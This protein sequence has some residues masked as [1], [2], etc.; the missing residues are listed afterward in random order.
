MEPRSRCPMLYRHI[1]LSVIISLST[2]GLIH[3]PLQSKVQAQIRV[4]SQPL[5]G[6]IARSPSTGARVRM[7]VV[8]ES[9]TGTLVGS[10]GPAS[11][12]FG[13]GSASG[14]EA[15]QSAGAARFMVLPPDFHTRFELD[16]R[17][18]DVRVR[19]RID[20]EAMPC[21]SL[22][23]TS[24]SRDGRASAAA[25]PGAGG[26]ECVLEY[27]LVERPSMTTRRL[28]IVVEDVN[29]WAPSFQ[30]YMAQQ[31][32]GYQSYIRELPENSEPF[33][34]CVELPPPVD[35]DAGR[36]GVRNVSVRGGADA[37][38]FRVRLKQVPPTKFGDLC[39]YPVVALDRE[40]QESYRLQIEAL[41]G[42]SPPRSGVLNLSL[43]IAD[44]NDNSP[45]FERERFSVTL[46]ENAARDSLVVRVMAH[47]ADK[48]DNAALTYSF[49]LDEYSS[50]PNMGFGDIVRPPF[51]IDPQS[52][53]LISDDTLSEDAQK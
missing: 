23:S 30:Q 25:A 42:G 47:D 32:G 12:S 10:L 44:A 19:S 41:D 3:S 11:A 5:S 7:R 34:T 48:E 16:D 2:L 1:L 46:P 43:L 49:D 4:D 38:K 9:A 17:S 31:Q 14:S 8:E 6:S 28:E 20:R 37:H 40:T 36:N 29:D 13:S 35:L 45:V 24:E 52:G 27:E 22:P 39:L 50:Q 15:V 51:R 33:T 53:T 18:G 26:G 21:N